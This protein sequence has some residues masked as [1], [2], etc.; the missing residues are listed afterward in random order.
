MKIQRIDL[1]ISRLKN[2]HKTYLYNELFDFAKKHQLSGRFGNDY[3][4]LSGVPKNLIEELHKL[5][6]KI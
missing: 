6:I 3:I 2:K 4:E 5:N 1:S